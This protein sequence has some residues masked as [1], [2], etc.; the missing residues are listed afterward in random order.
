MVF[1]RL[2][3]N[4]LGEIS[5]KPSERKPKNPVTVIIGIICKAAIVPASDSQT[6]YGDSKRRDAEKI[7]VVPFKKSKV[8]VAQAGALDTSSRVIDVMIRLGSH[9]DLE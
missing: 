6:T 3:V 8:L 2:R 5:A 4:N 1:R 9:R 7:R